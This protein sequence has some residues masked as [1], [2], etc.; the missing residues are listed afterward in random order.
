MLFCVIVHVCIEIFLLT[1]T[2]H[3][4]MWQAAKTDTSP[5]DECNYFNYDLFHVYGFLH[6]ALR[7]G[8]STHPN[9]FNTHFRAIKMFR[10]D[11][12]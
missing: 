3:G 5:F 8:C 4:H 6:F 9:V 2:K 12:I 11:Y 7:F 10:L 1:V